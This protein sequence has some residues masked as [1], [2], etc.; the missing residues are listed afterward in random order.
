M[1][2]FL[3]RQVAYTRYLSGPL[4]AVGFLVTLGIGAVVRKPQVR[5]WSLVSHMKVRL[6]F[7]TS[8]WQGGERV[9]FSE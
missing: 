1:S 8:E 7:R 2:P 5:V 3:V 4:T 6:F 9:G